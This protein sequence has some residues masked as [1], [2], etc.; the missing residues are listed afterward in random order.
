[1]GFIENEIRLPLSEASGS[2]IEK[3]RVA[4]KEYGILR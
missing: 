2:A 1:M 4:L 3:I